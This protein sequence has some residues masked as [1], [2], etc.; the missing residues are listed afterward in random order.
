MPDAFDKAMFKQLS[1]DMLDVFGCELVFEVGGLK[2]DHPFA[3]PLVVALK[4]CLSG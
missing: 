3:T 4:P 1:G 2:P